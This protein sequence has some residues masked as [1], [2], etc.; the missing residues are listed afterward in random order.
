MRFYKPVHPIEVILRSG[1]H[2]DYVF[3]SGTHEG[4]GVELAFGNDAFRSIGN[5]VDIIGNQFGTGHHL[6]VFPTA[7]ILGVDEHTVL[8]VVEAETVLHFV[9]TRQLDALFG[10]AEIGE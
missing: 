10:D 2:G 6:E 9:A 7:A 4:T 1:R 3:S 8:E 5:G